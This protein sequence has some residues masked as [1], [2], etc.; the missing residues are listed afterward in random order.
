MPQTPSQ[1]SAVAPSPPAKR[2]AADR[3]GEPD[4]S[5]EESSL[6]VTEAAVRNA[7][8]WLVSSILHLLVLLLLGLWAIRPQRTSVVE[9]EAVLEEPS[10]DIGEQLDDRPL[11]IADESIDEQAMV[12]PDDFDVVEDP[13]ATPPEIEITPDG[14]NASSDLES[15]LSGM[16]LEGREA[17]MREALLAAYGGNG[18]S[19]A[20]VQ[21]ALEWLARNQRPNG[22][23]SLRGPY[24]EGSIGENQSA[25]TAMAMLAFQGAGHTHLRGQFQPNVARGL[26]WL[27]SQQDEDGNFFQEGGHNHG[28]YTQAQ[29]TI[30]LCELWAMTRDTA[31]REPAEKAV[32]YCVYAQDPSRG[33]WK[34]QPRSGADLSV[35]G[36]MLMALQSAKMGGLAVPEKTLDRVRRFLD[37]VAVDDGA[38]YAYMANGPPTPSMTAEG[39]LCRQYLGWPRDD[40]RMQRGIDYIMRHLPSWK[41][42]QRNVYYWYYATQVLHHLA[43][44]EWDT[45]NAV[46]RDLLVAKQVTEGPEKGSWHPMTPTPDRWGSYG[47]RLFVTCLSV[48]ILEVYYRHLPLYHQAQVV[49]AK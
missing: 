34:Y 7:P 36:W 2:P 27:L 9:L 25:A 15:L 10:E 44:S 41:G 37:T 12:T 22:S 13:F 49:G 11:T 40:P 38:R 3:L 45:W 42:D 8:P 47:G 33:G 39:L 28:L 4:T 23:W 18:Q 46:T 31:I 19:E 35:T 16:A 14:L 32:Q 29:C 5:D 6:P 24:T 30:A 26:S 43:G 1:R 48:Y 17:G 20:A 21:R